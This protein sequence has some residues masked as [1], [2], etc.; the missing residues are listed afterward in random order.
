MLRDWD[1]FADAVA[2]TSVV[3]DL[4]QNTRLPDRRRHRETADARNRDADMFAESN[5]L[6]LGKTRRFIHHGMGR[7]SAIGMNQFVDAPSMPR[8]GVRLPL[9][10]LSLPFLFIGPALGFRGV[11]TG[12]I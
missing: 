8:L 4:S 10:Y 5:G 1:S 3:K 6:K 12:M 7:R 2:E 9:L 11:D